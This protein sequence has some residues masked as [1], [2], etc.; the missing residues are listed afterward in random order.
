MPSKHIQQLGVLYRREI[1][2]TYRFIHGLLLEGIPVNFYC[3]V[4]PQRV[5]P[6]AAISRQSIGQEENGA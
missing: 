5:Y 3:L 4:F 2:P 6:A 1:L